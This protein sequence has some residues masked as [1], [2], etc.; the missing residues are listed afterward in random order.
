MLG[1]IL[2]LAASFSLLFLPDFMSR[3]RRAAW[4]K[5]LSKRNGAL[6]FVRRCLAVDLRERN[7]KPVLGRETW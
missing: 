2:I 7:R 3:K 6:R 5:R 4:G 1:G